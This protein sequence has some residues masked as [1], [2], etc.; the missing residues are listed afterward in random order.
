MAFN[1]VFAVDCSAIDCDSPLGA[2]GTQDRYCPKNVKRS[3]LDSVILIHPTLGT[4]ILNWGAALV[5]LDFDID[6]TD[7][8]DTKQKQFFGKGS[9]AESEDS[10][11]ELNSF[12][13]VNLGSTTS[14][15]LSIYDIDADTYTYWSKVKCGIVK[16]RG[17]FTTVDD[18]I[19]G[20]AVG[21]NFS[22]IKPNVIF[23][24]GKDAVKRIDVVFTWESKTFPDVY[25]Y[26][27]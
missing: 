1:N 15:T 19:I 25:P 13:L 20:S 17:Y 5:A 21:I 26:P 18:E 23:D 4:P 22:S 27:L 12:Q 2:A 10:E 8:T 7:A 16:P 6:N 14:A 24:E 11:V 9:I 3:Q